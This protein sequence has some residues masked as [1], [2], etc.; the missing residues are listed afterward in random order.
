[1]MPN[2]EFTTDRGP[3][4]ACNG[5][6]GPYS[7]EAQLGATIC[8][9]PQQSGKSVSRLPEVGCSSFERRE[10]TTARALWLPKRPRR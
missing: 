1:M 6:G 3:C 8:E 4:Q 9:W 5:Y 10:G 2:P 7:P